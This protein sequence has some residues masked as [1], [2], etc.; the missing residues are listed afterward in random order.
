MPHVGDGAVDVSQKR[1]LCI[2][3]LMIG[4]FFYSAKISKAIAAV[5]VLASAR[6][7]GV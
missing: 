4:L 2:E 3:L 6:E 7:F 1:K 5:A